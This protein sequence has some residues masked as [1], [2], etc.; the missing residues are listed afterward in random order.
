MQGQL[1]GITEGLDWFA[2]VSKAAGFKHV[3]LDILEI[4]TASLVDKT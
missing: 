3:N 4:V 1:E 2:G